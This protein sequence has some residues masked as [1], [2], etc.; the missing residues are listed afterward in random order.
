MPSSKAREISDKLQVMTV[1]SASVAAV[2]MNWNAILRNLMTLSLKTGSYRTRQG[3][4]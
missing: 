4:P 3:I 1:K 2:G